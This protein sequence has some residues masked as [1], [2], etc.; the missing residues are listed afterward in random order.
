[1]NNYEN[2]NVEDM[3]EEDF[4]PKTTG[5]TKA[6][7]HC[8]SW[9]NLTLTLKKS[10]AVLL[11]NVSGSAQTGRVLALMGP[12]GA[13]KTTLL[14][15]LGNRAPYG[16]VTGEVTFGSRDFTTNDLYFVPQVDEV[17]GIFTLYEQIEYVGLLKCADREDMYRRLDIVLRAL[18]LLDKTNV[19]CSTLTGGELKKVSVGMGM[20]SNPGVFF[21]D[22]PTTGLDST[23]AYSIVKHLVDLAASLNIAVIMTIHQ[24][25]QMVFEMLQDLYIIEGGQMVFTGPLSC[26]EKYF[27]NLGYI[28]A[29][30]T[31]VPDFLMDL[32]TKAPYLHDST[33][34]KMYLDSKFAVN[35]AK[36]Q[37]RIKG[38]APPATPPPSGL[39]RFVQVLTFFTT[40]YGRDFGL[41]YQRLVYL[42]VVAFFAGTVFLQLVAET[43]YLVRYSGA[44][45]FSIWICL[46]SA[47]AATG[48]FARDR[49]QAVEQVRNAVVSPAMYC[50][51]Q[52]LASVP[53]NFVCSLV[54]Q[55]IFHWLS[56]INPNR[57]SFIYS[58]L[59]TWGH[60]MLMDAFVLTVVEALKDA[61]LCVTFAMIVMG[62]L[63]LFA[64]FFVKVSDMPHWVRWISYITPTKYSFDGYLYQI[65][66]SQ[67]FSVSGTPNFVSGDYLLENL[68]TQ[69][70]VSSWGM[71]GT[72]LAW[73]TLVRL[74]HLGIFMFQ[75]RH[76]RPKRVSNSA[77]VVNE[78]EPE[79]AG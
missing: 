60:L 36:E 30:K 61:M 46:F 52:M 42:I 75:V 78:V 57:E 39:S 50:F 53:F 23:A 54:F 20:I 21:L 79:K 62:W 48:H 37:R 13:G 72:L 55:S 47:V 9:T 56:R 66:H 31:S 73:A 40:Y 38:V 29:P 64:G 74:A 28:R 68:F 77:A 69:K 11:D 43:D 2:Y 5:D 59:L 17:N 34:K 25:A 70:G 3:F 65:F 8:L 41:Y 4:H 49:R 24:P 22:E 76:F 33:W 67:S 63:F 58:V 51:C 71:F 32:V 1:M 18:G 45:F 26:S 35:V 16:V 12:S 15:A 7:A 6:T 10:G 19:L 27:S 14:N 44:I